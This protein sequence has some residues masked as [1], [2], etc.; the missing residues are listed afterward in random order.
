MFLGV[1]QC[2]L[3]F[4]Q[5]NFIFCG[6]VMHHC[7]W[8]EVCTTMSLRA[9]SHISPFMVLTS[10]HVYHTLPVSIPQILPMSCSNAFYTSLH[11]KLPNALPRHDGCKLGLGLSRQMSDTDYKLS[12]CCL[13]AGCACEFRLLQLGRT[14][15]C[16]NFTACNVALPLPRLQFTVSSTRPYLWLTLQPVQ[17]LCQARVCH[18]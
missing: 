11:P 7:S 17:L 13:G 12:N 15:A 3:D 8:S 10:E 4:R 1:S 18:A 9:M 2:H 14:I 16:F 5:F 6:I